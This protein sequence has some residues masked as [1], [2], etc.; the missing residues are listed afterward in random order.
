MDK[1]VREKPEST[2]DEAYAVKLVTEFQNH[3]TMLE[4]TQKR[5]DAYKKELNDMLIAHGKP[6]DKGNLWIN[7]SGFEIKRE[8]R[9]SKTFNTSAAEAWAKENGHWD[10]V[11]EVIEVLSEDKL[12]GLAWNN[13]EIQEKVKT[14][15]VEKETWALKA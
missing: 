11:K 12:L 10:T 2:F 8:R 15:Y 6:D 1:I 5:V 3:K 4:T 7:T 14:L 13:E 9:V